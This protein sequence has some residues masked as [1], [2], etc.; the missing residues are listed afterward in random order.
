MLYNKNFL[1]DIEDWNLIDYICVKS[2]SDGLYKDVYYLDG[3]Y[4][5]ERSLTVYDKKFMD[6][7]RYIGSYGVAEKMLGDSDISDRFYIRVN[8]SNKRQESEIIKYLTRNK[9]L[10]FKQRKILKHLC[11]MDTVIKNDGDYRAL[12]YCGFSKEYQ[13]AKYD[14]VRFYFKTFGVNEAFH[15]SLKYVNY[16]D[17]CSVIRED[18]T[19]QI[20]K[21]LIQN[22]KINLRCIG[23]DITDSH[24]V[25]IKYYFSQMEKGNNTTELLLELK[26]YPQ[27]EKNV[28]GLLSTLDNV[29][30]LH[31]DLLQIAGGENGGGKSINIYLESQTRDKKKYYSMREGLVLRDIGGVYFLI[32][33]HEKHYYDLKNLF[34]VNDTGKVILEYMEENKVCTL[35]GIVSNLRSLIKDYCVEMYPMIYSDCKKFVEQ[36]QEA[37]YLQEVT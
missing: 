26:K 25:K 34:S 2:K 35:E 17:Q 3:H 8:I 19:F 29:S 33:I 9:G 14:S 7:V 37:G 16:F 30:K 24:S 20:V 11:E 36:L 12:Y 13:S 31:C 23:V 6:F 4:E 22:K 21:E 1:P 5:F 18:Q 27:Y 10:S 32:D 28:E 15:K